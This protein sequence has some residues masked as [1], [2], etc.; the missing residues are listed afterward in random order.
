MSLLDV[1][2]PRLLGGRWWLEEPLGA[3][4]AAT[5]WRARDR[6]DGGVV[7]VKLV[8]AV[9]GADWARARREALALRILRLPG[10]VRWIDDGEDEGRPY[11]VMNLVDGAPFP[12]RA[13]GWTGILPPT[14][15]LL[16]TLAA[17]HEAVIVHRD[18]KPTNVLVTPDDR[19]VVLDFGIARG[20]P[21]GPLTG[22][23]VG[24][25]R[26]L[27]PEQL[28]GGRVDARADLWSV[29]AMVYEVLAGRPARSGVKASW[30]ARDRAPARVEPLGA[31]APDVPARVAAVIDA[32][33]E[34]DPGNRP[35][36]A[37]E[38]LDALV[39]HAPAA[40][41]LPWLG[42]TA[43]V[44]ELVAR[45]RRGES[46]T[47]RGARGSGR[48]R[49]LDDAARRLAA[50]GRPV[51]RTTP[52]ARPFGSMR[53]A[54]TLPAFEDVRDA[55]AW[56]E[57]DL[58]ARLG[59]GAVVVADDAADLDRWT[60]DALARVSD[61]GAVLRADD[62]AHGALADVVLPP[63]TDADLRGAFAPNGSPWVTEDAARE[64]FRRT[65][66][67]PARVD[68]EARA[69]VARG[70]ARRS[71]G[72]LEVERVAVDRLGV[73]LRVAV[74]VAP[75]V[76]LPA[77]LDD[78][79]ATILLAGGRLATAVL[80]EVQELDAWELDAVVRELV[81]SGAA[82]VE[83]EAVVATCETARVVELDAT[84][85]RRIR[86]A[87]AARMTPGAP[88]RASLLA[89][90]GD[91][92]AAVE[93][94]DVAIA[95]ERAAGRD[96]R[97]L[98]LALEAL[99]A[100]RELSLDTP[101]TERGLLIAAAESAEP[102]DSDAWRA[103]ATELARARLTADESDALG[104]WV[105]LNLALRA[106][107]YARARDR[108]DHVLASELFRATPELRRAA[109]ARRCEA[110]LGLGPALGALALDPPANAEDHAWFATRA[111]YFGA[112]LAAV[113]GDRRRALAL[114][115][116]AAATA[117]APLD[118]LYARLKR[119]VYR[120]ALD[121]GSLEALD[122]LSAD[123]R[124]LGAARVEIRTQ[125]LRRDVRRRAGERL[126]AS[127]EIVALAGAVGD[128]GL[129][130]DV[131]LVEAAIAWA[132][133]E[134]ALAAQLGRGWYAVTRSNVERMFA[135]GFLVAAEGRAGRAPD[136]AVARALSHELR[137][138]DRG[139]TRAAEGWG[140]LR[141]CCPPE[142]VGDWPRGW[143]RGAPREILTAREIER[144]FEGR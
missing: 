63:L 8:H 45:A 122:A 106:C 132:A 36:T 114:A 2:G 12:G 137:A 133:E 97:A 71:E 30:G 61:A 72:R 20:A 115:E 62:G 41:P 21:L 134:W 103:I 138:A 34:I 112:R 76:P 86:L 79:L 81:E 10:V 123:A 42:S 5:V 91:W 3:G 32:M 117:A 26:F 108:A 14:R 140:L 31:L 22:G 125:S 15:A 94:V 56:V 129:A 118:A 40:A 74:N 90:G 96:G 139:S 53:S 85:R 9:T 48:S 35:S 23:S 127:P 128:T 29:A 47:L 84:E 70:L 110:S 102:A 99:S 51:L 11:I 17:V 66:G 68:A 64:M 119:E 13:R 116:Q 78:I 111:P 33:L 58:R 87:L 28:D 19:V 57:A 130:A 4:G 44:D 141:L 16:E 54:L 124:A 1:R 38:A 73:E 7:A 52:S 77:G 46:V 43:P 98:A 121:E 107:D 136:L 25:P 105:E 88:H 80:A 92:T 104:A 67:L 126:S 144:L 82:R 113:V 6:R 69:W 100:G 101:A 50:E 120:V 83:G 59:A 95:A 131:G 142:V 24:T 49:A 55:G 39:R 27:A 37:R 89:A 143:P 109:I 75:P 93:D 65:G 60:R 18:I 135:G